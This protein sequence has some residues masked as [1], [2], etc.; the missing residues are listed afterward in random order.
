MAALAGARRLLLLHLSERADAAVWVAEARAEFAG[1]VE[2]PDDGA[3]YP[4]I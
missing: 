4:V 1:P 2:V 3:V